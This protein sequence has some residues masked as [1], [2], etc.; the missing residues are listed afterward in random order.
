MTTI[1]TTWAR[2]DRWLGRHAPGSVALLAPPAD[3]AEI[4]AAERTLGVTFPPELVESLRCHD[5]FRDEATVLPR[6][7]PTGTT[8]ARRR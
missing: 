1:T 3:P 6:R 8:S 2:I 4:A 5:G 7:T